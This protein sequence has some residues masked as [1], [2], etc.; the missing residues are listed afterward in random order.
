M[1]ML[2]IKISPKTEKKAAKDIFPKIFLLSLFL[3]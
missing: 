3:S 2:H 1:A